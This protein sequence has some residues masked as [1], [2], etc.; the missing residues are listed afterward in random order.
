MLDI[1]DYTKA[2]YLVLATQRGLVKKTRL[3]DYDSNRSGGVI[4]INLREDEDGL[5]D[6]LVSARLVDSDQD[7][8][9]VSRKVSRCGSPRRTSR[10]ARWAG[11]RRESRA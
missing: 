10:C 1:R 3:S 6:E 5:P 11:P 8:I 9:L 2:E 7:L 4:A